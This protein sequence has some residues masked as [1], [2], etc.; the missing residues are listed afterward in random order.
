MK[1]QPIGPFLGINHYLPD[2][3]LSTENGDWLRDA[4]NVDIDNSGW[5]SRRADLLQ[6][7]AMT[8]AHS[9]Y[10][11]TDAEGYLVRGTAMYAV[12]LAPS[13]S[14]TLFRVLA[15]G[16]AVSWQEYDGKIYYASETDSGKIVGGVWYPMGLP[17]PAAPSCLAIAGTLFAGDYQVS[18]SYTNATTEEEGGLSASSKVTLAASGGLRITLPSSVPGASHANVYVSTVNGSIPMFVGSYVLGTAS[19]DVA[20][21]PTRLREGIFKDEEPLPN[22]TRLFL[23]NGQLCSISGK[24]LY[25]GIPYKPGYCLKTDKRVPFESDIGIA[26]GNQNGVYISAGKTYFLAGRQ[27]GP[28]M[29]ARVILHYG[30]VPGTEFAVD[31]AV[32]EAL[33]VGW[34]GARG[35]VFADINGS[36]TEVMATTVKQAPPASGVSVVVEEGGEEYRKVV[37]CGWCVNVKTNAVSRYSGWPVS[38]ASRGYVTVPTGVCMLSGG[39]AKLEGHISLGKKDFSAENLKYLPACYVG[40]ASDTPMELRVTTP[41]HEDYRYEARS[42]SDDM[43]IHRIDPGKGLRANWYDLSLYNTEGSDFALA[44]ASFAPVASGRR[45]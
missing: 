27:I 29:E 25:Y 26:I 3:S 44:S 32:P 19:V 36:A 4:E 21:E 39:T 7:Q 43:Q 42:C 8:D 28:D 22:G 23:F 45:I 15:S 13:Y 30:A 35:V 33:I 11:L 40:A 38:S 16:A 31:N 14:E 10:L 37:S 20:A 34:F 17:T 12:T 2:F 18:V 41:A 5:P 1:T 6:I 24:Y 9:L